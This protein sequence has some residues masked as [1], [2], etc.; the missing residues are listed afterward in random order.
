MWITD[1]QLILWLIIEDVKGDLIANAMGFEE[2]IRCEFRKYLVEAPGQR[3]HSW[4]N[5]NAAEHVLFVLLVQ[6]VQHFPGNMNRLQLEGSCV[7]DVAG[8]RKDR[9][10]SR[11]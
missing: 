7:L 6:V 11:T 9:E 10:D 3:S 5:L 8:L 4:S 2:T 1:A